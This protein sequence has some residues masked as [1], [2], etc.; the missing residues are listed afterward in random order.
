VTTTS[1]GLMHMLH[2]SVVSM[3][4]LAGNGD[5]APLLSPWE[6]ALPLG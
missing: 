3:H 1:V 5:Q 6:S 2:M 4:L